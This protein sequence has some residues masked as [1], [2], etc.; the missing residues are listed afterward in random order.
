MDYFC[1]R[2]LPIKGGHADS[3]QERRPEKKKLVSLLNKSRRPPLD[4]CQRRFWE[5]ADFISLKERVF[6]SSFN[7]AL[8][9]E[10]QLTEQ[11]TH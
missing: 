10:Y 6:F 7:R 1:Q 3:S 8:I 4:E 5:N 9:F 11:R 2:L